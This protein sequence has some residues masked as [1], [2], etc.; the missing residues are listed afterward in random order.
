MKNIGN[1][2]FL[3]DLILIKINNKFM[4]FWF[5]FNI[6]RD[7]DFNFI[8]DKHSEIFIWNFKLIFFHFVWIQTDRHR[9]I[10]FLLIIHE[11]I[12]LPSILYHQNFKRACLR[13]YLIVFVKFNQT[14]FL[15]LRK[16]LDSKRYDIIWD[17]FTFWLL[18]LEWLGIHS[19]VSSFPL[20]EIN[21]FKNLFLFIFGCLR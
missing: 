8:C 17:I 12:N 20:N 21:I 5:F 14:F 10:S 9:N 3:F 15:K 1:F 13:L 16:T 2:I 11:L 7:I 6:L 4:L 19:W 18:N